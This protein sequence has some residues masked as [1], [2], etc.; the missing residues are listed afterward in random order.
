MKVLSVLRH[1]AVWILLTSAPALAFPPVGDPNEPLAQD[2]HLTVGDETERDLASVGGHIVVDGVAGGHVIAIGG[3]VTVNGTVEADVVSIGATVQLGPRSVVKGGLLCLG[4]SL[5]KEHGAQ[6]LGETV[7]LSSP[8]EVVSR[9]ARELSIFSLRREWSPLAIG[10]RLVILFTW[11][12]I[13]TVILLAFPGQVKTAAEETSRHFLKFGLIGLLWSA[14][15]VVTAILLV[16]LSLVI[17]GIPLLL[18]LFFFAILIKLFGNVSIYYLCG[19]RFLSAVGY[20]GGPN[21][22]PVLTGLVLLGVIQFIPYVG[23][24]VWML[25]SLVGM[26]A[27]LATKFGTGQLWFSRKTAR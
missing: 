16:F 20:R 26:G 6:V 19:T 9:L 12:L 22:L 18:L 17:I 4:A 8:N 5:K 7:Y 10:I 15:L 27:A 14:A 24:L 11:F 2:I 21:I 13:A 23:G 1:A 3:S 25:L